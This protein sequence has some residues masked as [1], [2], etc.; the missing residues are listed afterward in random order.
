M[1]AN[2]FLKSYMELVEADKDV[3]EYLQFVYIL[4]DGIRIVT[5]AIRLAINF[6]GIDIADHLMCN[7]IAYEFK[8]KH[9]YCPSCGQPILIDIT[10]THSVF[11]CQPCDKLFSIVIDG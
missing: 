8:P 1:D 6:H 2:E 7:L 10:D 3:T 5:E 11:Q 9:F 4:P